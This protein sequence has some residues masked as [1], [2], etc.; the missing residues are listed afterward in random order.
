MTST[1]ILKRS[2][3]TCSANISSKHFTLFTLIFSSTKGSLFSLTW[4]SSQDSV[5]FL[6]NCFLELILWTLHY[7]NIFPCL[8]H[9]QFKKYF[10]PGCR[11]NIT[12]ETRDLTWT[13]D[14]LLSNVS[15]NYFIRP[16]DGVIHLYFPL[17]GFSNCPSVKIPLILGLWLF[18]N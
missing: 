11:C 15:E 13:Q 4:F 1:V 9:H 10:L 2:P 17:P 6:S 3:D 18:R 14:V 5:T 8:C 7:L 12:L 16:P